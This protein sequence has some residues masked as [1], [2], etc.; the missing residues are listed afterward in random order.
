MKRFAVMLALAAALFAGAC[1]S[2][3][4]LPPL[5]GV[6]E[7]T[8]MH[9][10]DIHSRAVANNAELGYARIATLVKNARAGNP[11]TL[12]LDA[13]DT[14]HGLPIANLERGASITRLMNAVG[15]DFMTVGN[16]DF[17]Y[18]QDRL[19]ELEK[20]LSFPILAANVYKNG[21]RVFKAWEIKVIGGVRVGIFGVTSPE[22]SY[23][24]DP[25]GIEGISFTD[26]VAEAK[27]VVAELAKKADIIICISHVGMDESS[28]P[29]SIDIAAMVP[30]IDI[31]IDGHS[32]TTLENALKAN[33]TGTLIASTGS[34]GT[35]LGR[36]DLVVGVDRSLLRR[37]ASILTVANSPDLKPDP[38]V[39]AISDEIKAIQDPMLA[40]QVGTTAVELIGVRNNVRASQTNLGTLIAKSM[41]D[42]SGADL[43]LMNGGGIRDSIPAGPITKRHIFTVLPFGNYAQ[44][45]E[46]TGA[47]IKAA[48]ENGVGKLPAP[49]GRYPHVAG[50]TFDVDAAQPVGS[51]VSN[52]L[53]KGVALDMAKTYILAAPNFTIAGGDEYTM[54]KG[55]KLVNEYPSDA[56][57]FMRYIRKLGTITVDNI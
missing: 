47:D 28:D 52:I 45:I 46:L 49:D 24:T 31:I 30:G 17:N 43:A 7:I 40:E 42:I 5:E 20:Q 38:A 16:H 12:V 3:P 50:A 33:T 2:G 4:S 39:L 23:K 11:N 53:I 1:A 34:Y 10:N 54:L 25:K 48:L 21:K 56:E 9:T 41:L 6:V 8:I 57:V 27:K 55:K 37:T 19:Y 15:Y 44:T 22:N 13:G 51:R 26:P 14:L 36:I 18:G 29:T 35:A 32:H